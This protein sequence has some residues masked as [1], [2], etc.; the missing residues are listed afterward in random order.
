MADFI[1][2]AQLPDVGAPLDA[3]AG[4]DGTGFDGQLWLATG[5]RAAAGGHGDSAILGHDDLRGDSDW[6]VEVKD[7]QAETF[8]KIR[9]W[10]NAD[11]VR[12]LYVFQEGPE[13]GQ[14]I[15]I[16]RDL[17]ASGWSWEDVPFAGNSVGGRAVGADLYGASDLFAGSSDNWIPGPA[18]GKLH[19][20][21]RTDSGTGGWSQHRAL[22]SPSLPWEA[23]FDDQGRLWEFWHDVNGSGGGTFLD[24]S[25]ITNPTGDVACVFYFPVSGHMYAC[26]DLEL[27]GGWVKRWTGSAWETVLTM[28]QSTLAEHV[29][30]VPRDAGELWAVGQDPFQVYASLDGTA[31]ELVFDP[32]ISTNQDTDQLCA[33]A[34][35]NERMWVFCNDPNLGVVRVFRED[36]QA[37]PIGA[38]LQII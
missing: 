34:F 5:G 23:E 30:Y 38:Q 20:K 27:R 9:D 22:T 17:G 26:G 14:S 31:W 28:S 4:L 21:D 25:S 19:R 7:P 2:V 11:G 35:Y 13:S 33:I 12:R 24:G 15:L 36:I 29:H 8:N 6:R 1:E 10:T 32:G 16:R 18:D 37:V 3:W